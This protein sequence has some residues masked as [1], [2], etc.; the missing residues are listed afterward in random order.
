MSSRSV[1]GNALL[2]PEQVQRYEENGIVFP[3][4]VVLPNELQRFQ[5]GFRELELRG[6]GAQKYTAFPHLYFPWVWELATLP[7]LLDA[8][9]DL[10]GPEL[11][12]D[13]SLLL[14]KYARDP[15]FAPWHQDGVRSGWYKTASVSAWIALADATPANGCMQVIPG[16]HRGGRMAHSDEVRENSLFGAGAEIEVEV[17]ES[18]AVCVALAAGEASFHHSSIVHGSPPNRSDQKRISL[19]V[20]FV[21]PLFRERHAAVPAVRARGSADL[22]HM[23]LQETPPSGEPD[24]CFARWRAFAQ[25]H[26]Q[27]PDMTGTPSR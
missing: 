26:Q 20:R 25:S 9:E 2:G 12:I 23:T 14:C 24:E 16:S 21:T 19:I 22:S 18:Q 7:R 10:I 3:V 13:S 1:R 17:D 11:V 15:A 4:P 6:G 8:A 27:R 5:E